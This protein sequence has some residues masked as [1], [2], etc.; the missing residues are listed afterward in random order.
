MEFCHLNKC[1]CVNLSSPEI[2][3]TLICLSAGLQLQKKMQV[4]FFGFE[5]NWNWLEPYPSWRDT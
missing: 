3:V 4:I 5:I 1:C 2:R